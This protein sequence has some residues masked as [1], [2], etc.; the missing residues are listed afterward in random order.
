MIFLK[1][2]E[3]YFKKMVEFFPNLVHYLMKGHINVD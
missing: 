2:N 1:K 3:K